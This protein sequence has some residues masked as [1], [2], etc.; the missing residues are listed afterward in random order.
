MSLQE[1]FDNKIKIGYICK[2]Q[3]MST[4]K[5]VGYTLAVLVVIITVIAL[6]AVWDLI[7]LQHITAKF[8]KSLIIIFFSSVV[9]LF[10]YGVVLKDNDN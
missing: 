3:K 6:L 9:L 2:K 1:K 8:V 10:I 4:K 7:D 5:L